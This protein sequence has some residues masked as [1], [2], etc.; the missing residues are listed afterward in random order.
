MI[1]P[2][3]EPGSVNGSLEVKQRPLDAKVKTILKPLKKKIKLADEEESQEMMS[4]GKSDKKVKFREPADVKIIK[5]E[6]ASDEQVD[7]RLE[8]GKTAA[9]PQESGPPL[10]PI[11]V[12]SDVPTKKVG[13]TDSSDLL[14][15]P[16]SDAK[17]AKEPERKKTKF[18]A[19]VLSESRKIVPNNNIDA[20]NQKSNEPG[21]IVESD[22]T[23]QP[24]QLKEPEKEVA[25]QP[26]KPEPATDLG[27]V[28]NKT[29]KVHL[30]LFS[31]AAFSVI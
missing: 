13:G 3:E 25:A 28:D 20:V 1:E 17:T 12:P 30:K 21:K 19:T 24:A 15:K 10:M 11:T 18:I 16:Q 8:D 14:E 23:K 29:P 6:S 31:S 9:E 27:K 7:S 5:C 22:P 4:N 2:K 26:K